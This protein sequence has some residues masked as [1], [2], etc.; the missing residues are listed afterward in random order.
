MSLVDALGWV[1]AAVGILLGL[2][3]LVHLI[4]TRHTEGVS[5]LAWQALLVLNLS[6]GL[7]G[8]LIGQLNMIVTNAFG[9]ATTVPIL[10][11]MCR[12]RG[13]SL[14]RVLAP[15]VVAAV[16]VIGAD[17]AFGSIA[18]GAVVLIPGTAV[19]VAQSVELVRSPSV[20]G[21]SPLFLTLAVVNQLL[22]VSWAF[23]VPEPGT[24]IAASVAVFIT[25]FNVLW[26]GLRR[27]GLRA[28]FPEPEL[29]PVA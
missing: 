15:A 17:L 5:L 19:N 4:R 21:V 14:L 27:L 12:S 18:F 1:A 11:L 2:P 23:L 28:F 25:T 20:E 7:H 3:Q 6:W 8:V 26:W 16:V 29:T 22:W 13:L 24:I 9:L 10:V